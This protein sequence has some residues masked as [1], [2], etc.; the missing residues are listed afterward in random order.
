MSDKIL[1][2]ADLFRDFLLAQSSPAFSLPAERIF[3]DDFSPG[4]ALP[5]IMIRR[6]DSL[7]IPFDTPIDGSRVSFFSR[8][9]DDPGESFSLAQEVINIL[10]G[11]KPQ[12]LGAGS[13]RILG[14]S[15]ESGPTRSDD[16]ELDQPQFIF[17]F[18]A[19][20]KC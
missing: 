5:A 19:R 10:H 13:A 16:D 20:V 18:I 15:L 9:A 8:S 3:L 2:I 14:V 6:D 1:D 17:N 4:V 7:N 12:S 11:V